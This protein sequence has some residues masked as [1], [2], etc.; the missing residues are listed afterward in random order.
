MSEK[1]FGIVNNGDAAQLI[2]VELKD[3]SKDP[4]IVSEVKVEA[5][6]VEKRKRGRPKKVT[7]DVKPVREFYCSTCRERFL[8][9]SIVKMQAGDNRYAAFCPGCTKFLSY[10][11]EVMQNT[12]KGWI[13]N[14]PTK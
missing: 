3:H 8:E 14:N 10:V 5:P 4:V 11:D 12:V 9:N 1:E 2:P 13:E 7:V 6:V